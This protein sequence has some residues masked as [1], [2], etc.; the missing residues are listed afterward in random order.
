MNYI[1]EWKLRNNFRAV[2]TRKLVDNVFTGYV[3][4]KSLK[5]PCYWINGDAYVS[6]SEKSED[7]DLITKKRGEEDVF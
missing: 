5:F 2:V 1:G 3:I 7:F 6:E 4:Y